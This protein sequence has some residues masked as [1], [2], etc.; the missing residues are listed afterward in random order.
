M[1]DSQIPERDAPETPKNAIPLLPGTPKSEPSTDPDFESPHSKPDVQDLPP[2]GKDEKFIR[3]LS[4]EAIVAL[5]IAF[6]N[7][8]LDQADIHVMLI[9]WM[10]VL[11]CIVLCLDALRRTEWAA[12]IGHKSKRF[13]SSCG[14]VVAVFLAFGVLLSHQKEV[15]EI[16]RSRNVS[17]KEAELQK[18]QTEQRSLSD[19]QRSRLTAIFSRPEYRGQIVVILVSGD[20]SW[21]YAREIASLFGGW[22]V[23][24]PF[25]AKK[26][27]LAMD[28]Q[29]SGSNLTPPPSGLPQMV[30]SS[31][32]FVQLKGRKNL[33]LDAD[34][35]SNVTLVWV[36]PKSPDGIVPDNHAPQ[37]SHLKEIL[38]ANSVGLPTIVMSRTPRDVKAAPAKAETT[39]TQTETPVPAIGER[40]PIIISARIENVASPSI[41]VEN[42][43]NTLADHVTWELVL[44]RVS[45]LA[46]LSYV[47][48]DIG[49]V[50]GRSTSSR[51]F[52]DLENRQKFTE[53]GD[54]HLKNGDELIGSVALD[55]PDCKGATYIVHFVWGTSGWIYEVKSIGPKLMLPKDMTQSGRR[56]FVTALE[57]S[58]P[59]SER[60]PIQ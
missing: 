19:Y 52:M 28:V 54:P 58:V 29:V 13:I 30:L 12:E 39:R 14:C 51:Y 15:A 11:A 8:A 44:F 38:A 41:V 7:L 57:Q 47:T 17:T 1:G 20:E 25:S 2:K 56:Q 49:Y 36:G 34:V 59:Q 5:I 3:P 26:N 18:K 27:D 48:A 32:Q 46:F 43:S 6:V 45:D 22:K 50:K 42:L 16:S 37:A 21:G 24:G 9:S 10:S 35:P 23:L 31:F 33:I 4:V 60:I 40:K 53:G 55:C